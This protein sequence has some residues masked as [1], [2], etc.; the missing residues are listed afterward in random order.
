M[1]CSW[2]FCIFPK[3]FTTTVYAK[4]R[5]QTEWIMGNWKIENVLPQQYSSRN[6][7][8]TESATCLP[9]PPSALRITADVLFS[10]YLLLPRCWLMAPS[11][12]VSQTS[13]F[14]GYDS[15]HVD[16]LRTRRSS[17]AVNTNR[18]AQ[19]CCV[20]CHVQFLPCVLLKQTRVCELRTVG[21]TRDAPS[22]L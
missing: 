11:G 7:R 15:L 1:K 3:Y 20:R 17:C 22:I 5:G 14:L 10:S 9:S 19:H 13:N 2:E 18:E 8:A 6:I 16:R 4:L 21:Y 12:G